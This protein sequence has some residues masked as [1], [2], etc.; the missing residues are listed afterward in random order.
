MI[1]GAALQRLSAVSFGAFVASNLAITAKDCEKGPRPWH[2]RV[3]ALLSDSTWKMSSRPGV[4]ALMSCSSSLPFAEKYDLEVLAQKG[5]DVPIL[6][7]LKHIAF[8]SI[9]DFRQIPPRAQFLLIQTF[10]GSQ[11]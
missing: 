10:S 1:S 4:S 8:T 11:P 5:L 6:D 9:A 7:L 3:E 2:S